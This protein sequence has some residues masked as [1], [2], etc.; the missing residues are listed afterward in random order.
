MGRKDTEEPV[1]GSRD[2]AV[3]E[4]DGGDRDQGEREG[5]EDRRGEP[6]TRQPSHVTGGAWLYKSQFLTL[7]YNLHRFVAILDI[8]A[9]TTSIQVEIF[10]V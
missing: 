10:G 7:W 8:I 1:L 2:N 6:N 5:T 9:T 3:K 4:E